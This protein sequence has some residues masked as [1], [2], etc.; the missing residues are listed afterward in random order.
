[1]NHVK[2]RVQLVGHVGANPEVKVLESGTKMARFAIAINESYKD[3]K[4]EQVKKTDWYQIVAW[5]RQAEVAERALIK[6]SHV[7]LEGKLSSRK[8]TSPDGRQHHLTEITVNDIL[9]LGKIN[10]QAGA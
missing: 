9:L 8:Y 4:G 5:G 10:L 7:S 1:M 2:N 3:R 6:G